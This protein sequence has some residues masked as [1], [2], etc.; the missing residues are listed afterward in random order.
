MATWPSLEAIA[1]SA[2][3]QHVAWS[4][5]EALKATISLV[6]PSSGR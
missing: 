3:E 5:S 2:K 6:R 4:V 1:G